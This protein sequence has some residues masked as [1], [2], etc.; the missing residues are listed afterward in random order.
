[1]PRV[2][3]HQ[4]V[5]RSAGLQ[6]HALVDSVGAYGGRKS[7]ELFILSSDRSAVVFLDFLEFPHAWSLPRFS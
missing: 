6:R 7:R 3:S 1:M 5:I 4:L 2:K